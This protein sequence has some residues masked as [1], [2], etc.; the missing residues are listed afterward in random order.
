M[1]HGLWKVLVPPPFQSPWPHPNLPFPSPHTGTD[2]Q[3][4]ESNGV[5][6]HSAVARRQCDSNRHLVLRR[7][8][9]R[10]ACI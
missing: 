5:E 7:R 8:H 10:S 4:E 2:Q 6:R 9:L 1:L 3:N